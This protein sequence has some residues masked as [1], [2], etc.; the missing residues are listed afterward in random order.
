MSSVAAT[1]ASPV[2]PESAAQRTVALRDFVQFVTAIVDER[3][4]ATETLR[5]I[6]PALQA[7]LRDDDWLLPT[8]TVPH[9][10]HYQQ[11][12]LHCDAQER[13]SVVSFVWGP[14][15]QTPIHDHGVWGLIGM[16]RGSEI[17]TPTA[18]EPTD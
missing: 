14:G 6:T 11:Y 1:A 12:L 17:S 3:L 10:D 15:Q 9:D 4:P 16:L 13:F 2:A 5:R 7:L 8:F 18:P